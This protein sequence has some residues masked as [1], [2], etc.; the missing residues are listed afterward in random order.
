MASNKTTVALM[1]CFCFDF[2]FWQWVAHDE[3]ITNYLIKWNKEINK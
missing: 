3:L 2:T 1:T